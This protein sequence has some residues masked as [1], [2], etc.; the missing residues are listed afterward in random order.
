MSIG[1]AF[2]VRD[3]DLISLVGTERYK[4]LSVSAIAPSP[5]AQGRDEIQIRTVDG[6]TLRLWADQSVIIIETGG[7]V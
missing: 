1:A 3:G 7:A 5:V 6:K 4:V 2:T